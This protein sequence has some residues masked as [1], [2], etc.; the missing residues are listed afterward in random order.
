MSETVSLTSL[1]KPIVAYTLFLTSLVL[2]YRVPPFIQDLSWKFVFYSLDFVLA[3]FSAA[4][5]LKETVDL[6]NSLE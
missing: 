5:C 3:L 4:A 2:A 6:Y 1:W